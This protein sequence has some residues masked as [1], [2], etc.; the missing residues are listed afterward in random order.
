[1]TASDIRKRMF[2]HPSYSEIIL[3]ALHYGKQ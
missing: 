3:D 2:V 1:M